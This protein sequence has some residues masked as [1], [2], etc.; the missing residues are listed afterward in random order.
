MQV[1]ITLSHLL[2]LLFCGF[3][4]AF[5]LYA[6]QLC[7]NF[8]KEL[9]MTAA[10]ISHYQG[11]IEKIEGQMESIAANIQHIKEGAA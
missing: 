3:L 2:I 9:L 4:L 8:W 11:R 10:K 6:L 7:K 5:L 1:T